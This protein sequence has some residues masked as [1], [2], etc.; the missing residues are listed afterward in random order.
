MVL[1][2]A[3][4]IRPAVISK[5]VR[6]PVELLIVFA[7]L[8]GQLSGA[9]RLTNAK[10]EGVRLAL[11]ELSNSQIHLFLGFHDVKFEARPFALVQGRANQYKVLFFVEAHCDGRD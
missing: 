4:L 6:H 1:I 10:E 8:V 5:F 11:R 3:H 9:T 2:R 7:S